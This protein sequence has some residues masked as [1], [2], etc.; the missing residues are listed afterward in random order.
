MFR[1][2]PPRFEKGYE[3][4]ENVCSLLINLIV[5]VSAIREMS[6]DVEELKRRLEEQIEVLKHFPNGP[7]YRSKG[8]NAL[9]RYLCSNHCVHT[10]WE[11]F[12]HPIGRRK[13]LAKMYLESNREL[14]G[15]LNL[16]ESHAV[17]LRTR[18]CIRYNQAR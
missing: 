14:A 8:K 13:N 10:V 11:C 1:S 12:S 17:S 9:C 2:K 3:T 6:V 18:T 15:I 7:N 4:H 5:L 16:V